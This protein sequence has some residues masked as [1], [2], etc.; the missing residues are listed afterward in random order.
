[1]KTTT[2]GPL[3]PGSLSSGEPVEADANVKK[4]FLS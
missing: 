4:N 2:I 1:M 3:I